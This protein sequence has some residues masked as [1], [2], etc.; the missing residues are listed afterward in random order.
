MKIDVF[1]IGNHVECDLCSKDFTNSDA[2]GGFLFS[3]NGVCPECSEGCLV[4]IEKYHEEKYIR[5]MADP[6]ETFRDFIL[7]L[8]DN[9]NS[10]IIIEC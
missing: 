7:R 1:D 10:V 8:R 6:D 5:A 2:V 3:G 4:D 9:D